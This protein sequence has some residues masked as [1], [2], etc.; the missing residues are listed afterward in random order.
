MASLEGT[1]DVLEAAVEGLE[2]EGGWPPRAL[3]LQGF[4]QGGAAALHL[5]R[6]LA[7][8]GQ[9]LGS[10]VAV[11]ASL[12]EEDAA[13]GAFGGAAGGA[14]D[15][16]GSHSA[17]GTPVLITRGSADQVV[18]QQA[19]DRWVRLHRDLALRPRPS[20]CRRVVS[21]F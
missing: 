10:C 3:H 14:G 9:R 18:T 8:R 6:R 17:A 5:V 2:A 12:L 20:C 13:M 7:A 15:S 19:L 11:A 21:T 16:A 4:S 1:L